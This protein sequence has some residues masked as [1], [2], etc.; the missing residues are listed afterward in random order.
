[1][2]LWVKRTNFLVLGGLVLLHLILISIQIP[3]GNEKKLFE[4][5]V[6]FVFSPLQQLTVSAV[7]GIES[8]WTNYFDLRRVRQDNQKLKQEV[9][10]LGQE[11]RFLEDRLL[12][13]RTEAEVQA[14]LA[15]FR[16]S[17]ITARVIGTDAENVFRS[18]IL[19]KGSLAGITTDMPVCDKNGNLVGRTIGPVSLN[20][21]VVQ[22]ITD[23]EASV[24]VCCP[25]SP[26]KNSA[27]RPSQPP[28]TI[29]VASPASS[30]SASPRAG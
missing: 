16:D 14:N 6:F 24:S 30:R 15:R 20:E 12:E 18:L 22:L 11:K 8:A 26:L 1:M 29:L 3:L 4:R 25:L 19:N 21:A 23:T 17:L 5:A 9:F 27:V 10:F 28:K 2:P 7:R 13:F